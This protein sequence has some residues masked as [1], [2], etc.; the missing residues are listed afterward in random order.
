M[1][2]KV[3]NGF[4]T[5]AMKIQSQRHIAAIKNG[6]TTL[7]PIIIVGSFCTLFNSV[8]CSTTPGYLSLA[9]V[10]G[11]SWLANLS[12]IFTAANYGSMSMIA[13][14][15]C[16]L[17]SMELAQTILGKPDWSVPI[18]AICCYI[19]LVPNTIDAVVDGDIVATVSGLAASTTNAQGLFVAM[20]AALVGTEIYCRLVKWGKLEIHMPEQV[21]AN[22]AGSFNVLFP[23]C[24][25]VFIVSGFGWLFGMVTG[26]SLPDAIIRFIQTP[27]ANIM[28]SLAGYVLLIFMTDI[29][30]L[31]G[32]HGTQT[33]NG[34]YSPFMLAAFAEN[35]AVFAAGLGAAAAP[36]IICQPFMSCFGIITGA[37]LTGG[38]IIAI[39]L[40]SKRDD[41]KAIARLALPCGIFNINE[42][43]TFGLP[44]VMNPFLAVPF[45]LAPAASNIIGYVATSIGFCGK[46]VV[47]APWTTPPGIMAFL[48]SAGSIGAAVTQIL[49]IIVS[50]VI[51]TPFVIAT[52]VQAE[53]QNQAEAA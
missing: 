53:H 28:G 42:P 47:N 43:M 36:N 35:E 2:E 24:I 41:Y 30:W 50:A 44:I 22:V 34:I 19:S 11:M 48:S 46:M 16:I 38:L 1:G 52:N 7:L 40:F 27:L 5:V 3:M 8:L 29:L 12:P 20:L 26:M 49:V 21:P 18:T 13:I 25:T 4:L 9:N 31:F 32:I 15:A 45:C 51:Y 10:P 39:F 23:C 17:I 6:F 33:L 14:G 37:G